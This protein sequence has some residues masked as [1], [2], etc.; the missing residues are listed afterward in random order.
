MSKQ[1]HTYMWEGH[2]DEVELA[3]QTFGDDLSSSAWWAHG[4]HQEHVL[5]ENENTYAYILCLC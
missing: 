2:V 1:G 5:F 3:L 4:Y